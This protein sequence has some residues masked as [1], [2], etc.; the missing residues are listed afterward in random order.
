MAVEFALIVPFLAMLLFGMITTGLTYNDHLSVANAV[1]EGGRFGA[2]LD[3]TQGTWATSVRDRVKD[4][5][6]SSGGTISDAQICVRILNNLGAAPAS[7]NSWLGSS[8][9]G[10]EPAGLPS[11]MA[12]GSCVVKIW[13][14]KSAG[15]D[16]V[17]FPSFSFNI[18]A[19]SYSYYGRTVSGCTAL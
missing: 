3:Y 17:I 10:S 18:G 14:T 1:R 12:A 5:Y 13:V 19:K 6:F 4:T 8:C 11:S 2:G 15:I 16:L 9:S 7:S